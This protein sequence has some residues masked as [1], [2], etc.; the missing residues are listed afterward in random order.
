MNIS[1]KYQMSDS[2]DETSGGSLAYRRYIGSLGEPAIT[3]TELH[4]SCTLWSAQFPL[5]GK[6]PPLF[7]L[8]HILGVPHVWDATHT[9]TLSAKCHIYPYSGRE[10]R[11]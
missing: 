3:Q 4:G 2:I 9:D 8:P 1:A 6:K 11:N 10:Q 7:N 5:H